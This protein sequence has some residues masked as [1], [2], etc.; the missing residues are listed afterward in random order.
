MLRRAAT[1]EVD[2]YIVLP[3]QALAY[4]IGA[5]KIQLLRAQAQEAL[6]AAFDIRDFHEAVLGQG[7]VPL[8]V[9]EQQVRCALMG[10]QPICACRSCARACHSRVC[11]RYM[12]TLRLRVRMRNGTGLN[13]RWVHFTCACVRARFAHA[14]QPYCADAQCACMHACMHACSQSMPLESQLGG[15]LR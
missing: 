1:Q 6:G 13:E 11:G 5:L 2:R 9:L 7:S 10:A 15:Q 4:K 3:G 14:T 12:L 8:F